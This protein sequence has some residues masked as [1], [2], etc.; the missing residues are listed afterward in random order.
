MRVTS[1]NHDIGCGCWFLVVVLVPDFMQVREEHLDGVPF[2]PRMDMSRW[3]FALDIAL[4]SVRRF[5]VSL[6]FQA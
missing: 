6:A 3:Q 4:V 2:G 1:V 5:F